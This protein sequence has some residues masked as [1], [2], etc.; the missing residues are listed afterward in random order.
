MRLR[1]I[2]L[3]ITCLVVL[4]AVV[5]PGEIRAAQAPEPAEFVDEITDALSFAGE[6]EISKETGK[7]N[8]DFNFLS[9]GLTDMWLYRLKSKKPLSGGST[10]LRPRVYIMEYE[11]AA[12]AKAVFE[13]LLS[14]ADPNIG[15]SYAWDYVVRVGNRLYRLNVPCILSELNWRLMVARIEHFLK[16]NA[17]DSDSFECRCG[18]NCRR[19]WKDSH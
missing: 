9:K 17:A 10:Y 15:L 7:E 8:G 5:M 4:L 13:G 18:F 3:R 14:I 2:C 12:S 6:F 19:E 16:K 1:L 11:D